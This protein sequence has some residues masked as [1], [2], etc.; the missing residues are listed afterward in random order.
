VATTTRLHATRSGFVNHPHEST[1]EEPRDRTCSV[2]E[3]RARPPRR[4]N[5][6]A[7][8]AS[9][10]TLAPALHEGR[11]GPRAP[12]IVPLSPFPCGLSPT[13]LRNG[14]APCQSPN[15]RNQTPPRPAAQAL[16]SI[17]TPHGTPAPAPSKFQIRRRCKLPAGCAAE[18]SATRVK[19]RRSAPPQQ[20]RE[21]A[22]DR[23]GA[24]PKP[25]NRGIYQLSLASSGELC[26]RHTIS[27]P[28]MS[29]NNDRGCG[30]QTGAGQEV[31]SQKTMSPII[32]L[33]IGQHRRPPRNLSI[34]LIKR[35]TKI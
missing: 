11:P 31:K 6:P 5:Q 14:L 29:R 33:E 21:Q 3:P 24:Q 27:N 23:K 16:G 26:S 15:Q 12:P 22:R 30:R 25:L 2:F 13:P 7:P 8:S 28:L 1:K 4:M 9:T 17:S 20:R 34:Q 32:S 35:S 10:P 19:V 18:W